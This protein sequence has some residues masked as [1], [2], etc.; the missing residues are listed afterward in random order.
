VTRPARLEPGVVGEWLKVHALWRVEGDHLVREFA[1]VDYPSSVRILDDQVELAEHLDHH[2][3][4]TLG[5]CHLRFE[6]WTHDRGGLTRLDLD[7]AEGLDTI[8]ERFGVVPS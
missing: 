7:Y 5:Y 4:V 1:T 8:V 6:L 2:P 3:I